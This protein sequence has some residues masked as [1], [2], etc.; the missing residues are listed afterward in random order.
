MPSHASCALQLTAAPMEGLT[1]VVFRRLHAGMFGS[2]DRYYIPFVTPTRE[3]RFTDRQLRE[4][5]PEANRGLTAIPQLLTRNVEDFIWAAKALADMGYAEVNLNLGCPAG[6]VTAKGKGSGFL[7]HP[8]ELY[9]FLSR[10]FE[11]DLPIG[12]SLKTRVGFRDPAE[13]ENLA[14]LYARFP[15]TRLIVHP[16]LKTDLYR[17]RVRLDVLE[18][19]LPALPMPL[20]YNGDVTTPADIENARLRFAA[21]SG[22]LVEVMVGRALMADPALFRK[23][24]GGAPATVS[25]ILSFHEALFASYAELFDSQ[26]NAMMRMKEYWFYQLCLFGE[27]SEEDALKKAASAIFRSRQVADFEAAVRNALE[28]FALRRDARCG[29]YKP[30]P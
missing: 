28:S 18:K 9:V 23:A 4:L 7:Q 13:F 14:D 1:T 10:I 11:A 8:Q 22:G 20:G 16:R 2:A 30:L 29:W 19:A 3:P 5:A 6:T 17:G 25:E 24:R 26:K 21:A 27:D 12:I 15:M